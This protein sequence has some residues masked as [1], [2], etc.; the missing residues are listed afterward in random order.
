MS[1]KLPTT[2]ELYF[3]GRDVLIP[4]DSIAIVDKSNS[5]IIFKGD[6][7]ALGIEL[8]K[9]EWPRFLEQYKHYLVLTRS[10][11]YATINSAP[12]YV[13]D[14]GVSDDDS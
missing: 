11:V 8:P 1:M 14:K 5:R 9:E 7:Y 10:A 12:I 2:V 4:L 3:E 6:P 13:A